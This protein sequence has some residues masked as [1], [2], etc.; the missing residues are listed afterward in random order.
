M[1]SICKLSPGRQRER[2][3]HLLHRQGLQK[4]KLAHQLCFGDAADG[5]LSGVL[6]HVRLTD[7]GP[8]PRIK[9]TSCTVVGKALAQVGVSGS[10]VKDPIR[11]NATEPPALC[12]LAAYFLSSESL[13]F[14][15]RTGRSSRVHGLRIGELSGLGGRARDQADG[16]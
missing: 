16:G 14:P 8:G 10:L 11:A 12:Q 2:E 6:A 15:F 1:V 13:F 7:Q 3:S 5:H 4:S 9:A